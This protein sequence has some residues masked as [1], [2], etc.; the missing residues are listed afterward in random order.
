MEMEAVGFWGA[1]LGCAALALVAALLAFTRSARRVALTGALAALLSAVYTLVFLGWVP[2]GDHETLQRL[3]A[4]TAIATAAVLAVLLFMLLGIFRTRETTRRTRRIVTALAAIAA[5]LTWP[6]PAT[7]ALELAVGVCIL[8]T[9]AA[10]AAAGA[11]A[12]RGE[13]TGWLSLG[14]LACMCVGMA[15]LDWYA[16]HPD[17]TPWPVHAASAVGAIAY[18]ICIA[19]AIGMRYAYLIEVSKVMT[20]GRNFDPVTSMPSYEA[21]QPIAEPFAGAEDRPCGIIVVSISNLKMLEE[22]HGRAAYN[23]AL[24]VCAS[25]LRRLALPGTELARLRE[26]AFLLVVRHPRDAQQMI[27]HSRH[28]LQRLARPVM[29]GTSREITSLEAS[30]A[31]WQASL[32]IGVLLDTPAADP[33]VTVAGARAMSRTAWSY[34]SR[35]AWYDEADGAIAELPVTG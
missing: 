2:V 35:M 23:H 9:M 10:F 24:F 1:F 17:A 32:G 19:T 22:L 29:L 20:H 31:M 28:I 13:R 8:V 27:G 7:R 4:I 3:Q 5:A 15:G 11:S 14:A 16:F 6:V 34:A 18:L 30:Q 33:A 21:G 26:D 12:R 25:R